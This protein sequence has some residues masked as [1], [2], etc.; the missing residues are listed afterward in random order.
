MYWI[1]VFSKCR[2]TDENVRV[3]TALNPTALTNVV[4]GM[5]GN[6]ADTQCRVLVDCAFL[7]LGL[8]LGCINQ[9]AMSLSQE[10]F[11]YV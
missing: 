10:M 7:R 5:L 4:R 6:I 11:T 3:G 9:H 1:G 8:A 2:S